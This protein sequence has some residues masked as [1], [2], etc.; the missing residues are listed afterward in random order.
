MG[1][2]VRKADLFEAFAQ[3]GK[4]LASPKRL[5]LLDLLA[6][7]ERSV[8]LL[9]QRAGLGLTTASNHL[10][11]LRRS[12]L[13]ATRKEG[14]KVYYRLAGA[15]V[16]ALWAELR[17]VAAAHL[18]DVERARAAYLGDGE[19][20]QADGVAQVTRDELLRRLRTGGVTVIDVRPGEEY[21]AGHIPGASSL[22]LDELAG[23][24]AELPHDTT[25]VAYCRGAY[26]VMA[27]D[28]VRRLRTEGLRAVRLADGM[29]EWRLAD[30]PVAV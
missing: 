17:E 6:Q 1:D 26:C 22:P 13:V 10:Q 8:E 7:G 18:A 21:A 3:V 12:G 2:S 24:L 9:A 14:T 11:V 16:A 28:A 4:A 30:L 27:H 19:A 15:D 25:I 29:L 20:D 5:E 23:R